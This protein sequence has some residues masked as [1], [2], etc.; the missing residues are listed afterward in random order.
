MILILICVTLTGFFDYLGEY[1]Y[2]L[3]LYKDILRVLSALLSI[4]LFFFIGIKKLPKLVLKIEFIF[5][6]FFIVELINGFQFPVIIDGI[7]QNNVTK[8]HQ[9]FY[10]TYFL[11]MAS[12]IFSIGIKLYID[13]HSNNLYD[14]KVKRRISFLIGSFLFLVIFHLVIVLLYLKGINLP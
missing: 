2:T 10:L 11:S 6:L 12:S 9:L 13:R 5:I 4:N 3:K 1:G 8:F 7:L 14:I